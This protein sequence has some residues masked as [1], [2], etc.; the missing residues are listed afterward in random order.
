MTTSGDSAGVAFA[1][2][3]RGGEAIRPAVA[4][5]LP[6]VLELLGAAILGANVLLGK[7]MGQLFRV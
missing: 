4:A 6:A 3:S 2:A 7:R 5:D 1:S